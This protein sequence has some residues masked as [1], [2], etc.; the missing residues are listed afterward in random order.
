MTHEHFISDVQ[1]CSCQ[2]GSGNDTVNALVVNTMDLMI[3]GYLPINSGPGE[4][5]S[6][7]GSTVEESGSPE[8]NAQPDAPV[9]SGGGLSCINSDGRSSNG[10]SILV[11]NAGQHLAHEVQGIC[12]TNNN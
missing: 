12:T 3:G 6:P 8:S 7:I 11:S 9:C 1:L 2:D 10:E 5:D 4:T